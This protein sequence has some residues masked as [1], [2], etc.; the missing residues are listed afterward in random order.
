MPVRCAFSG[1]P[2]VARPNPYPIALCLLGQLSQDYWPSPH[3][4][5]CSMCE[6]HSCWPPSMVLTCCCLP[7]TTGLDQQL[8]A[9]SDP[10]YTG[11]KLPPQ[12]FMLDLPWWFFASQPADAPT[13]A[14]SPTRTEPTTPAP[15][16]V[17]SA[18]PY[19]VRMLAQHIFATTKCVWLASVRSQAAT[20]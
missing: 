12:Q 1:L 10:T 2:Y 11:P 4:L 18:G 20:K 19:T 6:M 16:G 14:P 9:T 17:P 13:A 7:Q 15:G 3:N 5:S 8:T